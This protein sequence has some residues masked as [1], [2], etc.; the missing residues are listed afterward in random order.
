[1]RKILT[2][3]SESKCINNTV[4]LKNRKNSFY[5]IVGKKFQDI[6]GQITIF[7]QKSRTIQD[8]PGHFLKSRTFQDFPGLW[9]P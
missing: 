4:H 6:S 7:G 9:P 8:N 5:E 3:P 1:M 2:F